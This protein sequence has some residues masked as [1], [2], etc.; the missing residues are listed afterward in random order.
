MTYTDDNAVLQW[1]RQFRGSLD[2]AKAVGCFNKNTPF[3]HFH[4]GCCG[5][6]SEMLAE[7][8]RCKGIETIYVWGWWEDQSHAWLV[9][10]DER[11]E[12]PKRKVTRIPPEISAILSEYSGRTVG[13]SINSTNYKA[14]DVQNGLIID[15]T[16]DQFGEVP[17]Y[18]GETNQFYENFVFEA[19]NGSP[20]I[21]DFEGRSIYNT[22]LQFL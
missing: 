4:S 9:V 1:A 21:D 12:N 16:A 14:S 10:K 19:A 2:D 7:F 15:I 13:R 6:T 17:V 3:S 18:V 11:V 8:L 5:V 22:V 20:R